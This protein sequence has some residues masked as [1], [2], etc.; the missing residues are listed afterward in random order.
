LPIVAIGSGTSVN[1]LASRLIGGM[2]ASASELTNDLEMQL[3]RRHGAADVASADRL[4]MTDAIEQ[5][6]AAVT[7]L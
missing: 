5:R 4:H 2:G 7:L 3:M 1:D 6:P